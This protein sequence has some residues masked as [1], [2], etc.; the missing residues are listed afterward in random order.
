MRPCFGMLV[1]SV[2]PCIFARFFQSLAPTSLSLPSE[3][4]F[5]LKSGRARRA[6]VLLIFPPSPLRGANGAG[7]KMFFL[8]SNPVP[9]NI[10]EKRP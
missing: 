2:T 3:T 1:E 10:E 8:G 7:E 4:A 6:G 5:G 9:G